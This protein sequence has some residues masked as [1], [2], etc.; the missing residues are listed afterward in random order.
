VIAIAGVVAIGGF[1][2]IVRTLT[3]LAP[4]VAAFSRHEHLRILGGSFVAAEKQATNTERAVSEALSQQRQ[5]P[6]AAGDIDY[7][8]VGRV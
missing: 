7:K 5:G 6:A 3:R 4:L 2:V 8:L 1:S